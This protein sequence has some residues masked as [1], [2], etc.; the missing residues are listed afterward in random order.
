MKRSVLV[1]SA[2]LMA[3]AA[4][5]QDPATGFP[6]YGSF[7][8]GRFDAVNR[9]NLNVNFAIP[10]VSVPGRGTDFSFP[11]VYDSLIWQR[12]TSGST[13]TWSPVTD[14]SG[15]ATW[16]WTKDWPVGSIS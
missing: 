4:W 2:F 7:E 1:L 12:V 9:R 8:V 6:P 3:G 10:I 15:D 16:G 11:L 14:K 13:T 5:A